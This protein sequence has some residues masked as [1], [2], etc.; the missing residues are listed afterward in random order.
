MALLRAQVADLI[1]DGAVVLLQQRHALGDRLVARP[2][3]LGVAQHPRDRHTRVTQAAQ[4]LQP[5]DVVVGEYAPPTRRACD[6]ADQAD[7][8]VVPQR[9]EAEAGPV[10]D[11]PWRIAL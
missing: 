7:A 3:Q 5:A 11:L 8:F 10:D 9:V 1:V 2:R 6:S 4:D